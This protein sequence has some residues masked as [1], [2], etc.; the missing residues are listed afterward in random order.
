M[1]GEGLGQ[2]LG[3]RTG[4]GT[5]EEESTGEGE[6]Q[7]LGE[8]QRQGLELG[9]GERQGTRFAAFQV[10]RELTEENRARETA[11]LTA[12]CRRLEVT[13]G[14]I[15]TDDQEWEEDAEGIKINVRPVWRWLLGAA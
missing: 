13:E 1:L 4:E 7:G 15:L 12:A 2:G 6:G 10:C 3:E 5:G 9:K 11:G 8:R 14:T